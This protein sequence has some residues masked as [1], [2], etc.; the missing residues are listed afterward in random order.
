MPL[1]IRRFHHLQSTAGNDIEY[2]FSSSSGC[3]EKCSVK[4][5]QLAVIS[6][7]SSSDESDIPR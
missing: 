3:H 1:R 6:S 2:K 4:Y 5:N 7:D